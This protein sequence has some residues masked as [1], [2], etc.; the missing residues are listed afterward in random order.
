M[1]L[2]HLGLSVTRHSSQ[3]WYNQ[4]EFVCCTSRTWGRYLSPSFLLMCQK[5]CFWNRHFFPPAR[6]IG[7]S[8][9]RVPG[10]GN[11]STARCHGDVAQYQSL[12]PRNSLVYW[13]VKTA[14]CIDSHWQSG[15]LEDRW[16]LHSAL[17]APENW[18]S[19][20]SLQICHC[21]Q[22]NPLLP[23]FLAC[24]LISTDKVWHTSSAQGCS[25]C[26]QEISPSHYRCAENKKDFSISNWNWEYYWLFLKQVFSTAGGVILWWYNK[27]QI[28]CVCMWRMLSETATTSINWTF[29]FSTFFHLKRQIILKSQV[30]HLE[31]T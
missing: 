3:G 13:W 25:C 30:I 22:M 19:S 16:L 21:F 1:C 5:K 20:C 24:P 31:R 11:S 6:V 18:L 7:S 14:N 28:P 29:I 17:T 10:K 27:S 26:W 8:G 23:A 12:F 4:I 15:S 9:Q 2:C